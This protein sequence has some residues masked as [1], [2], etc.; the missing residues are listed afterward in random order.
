MIDTIERR[1]WEPP[2]VSVYDPV[3]EPVEEGATRIVENR[4]QVLD[5]LI[6]IDY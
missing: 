6:G 4:W 1:V 2:V 5:T 3:T